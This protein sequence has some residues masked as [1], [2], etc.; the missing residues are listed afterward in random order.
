[1]NKAVEIA[2]QCWRTPETG[3]KVMDRDLAT[4]FA[5][6]ITPLL[7]RIEELEKSEEL[8]WGIIANAHGG[9]W[10]KASD[11]WRDAAVRWRDAFLEH[12]CYGEVEN[13]SP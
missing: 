10:D 4:A 13:D 5:Q 1:M 2:I 7:E 11:I 9:D 6:A 12:P 8:A 3:S